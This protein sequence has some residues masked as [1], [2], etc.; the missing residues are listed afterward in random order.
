MTHPKK[1]KFWKKIHAYNYT[2]I[3]HPKYSGNI[4]LHIDHKN[5]NEMFLDIKKLLFAFLIV[6]FH[7]PFLF[8]YKYQIKEQI[9]P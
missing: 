9:K 5:Y 3:A 7:Y 8:I 6:N 4:L 2:V 1:Q